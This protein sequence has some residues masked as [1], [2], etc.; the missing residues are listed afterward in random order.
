MGYFCL[1]G[2]G[3]FLVSWL[4]DWFVGFYAFPDNIPLNDL[5]GERRDCKSFVTVLPTRA[6]Y[7]CDEGEKFCV[8]PH[9]A[10]QV[11]V[12]GHA[13]VQATSTPCALSSNVSGFLP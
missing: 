6:G 13:G 5:H 11:E 10:V 2:F 12:L 3:V 7:S 8:L 1:V 4:V 9:P